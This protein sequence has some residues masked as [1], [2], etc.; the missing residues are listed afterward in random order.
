MTGNLADI[1]MYAKFQD[2]IFG[3]GGVQ[4][5][6]G[7]NLTYSYSFLHGPYNNAVLLCCL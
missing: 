4:F 6:S 7:S 5:Y 2:D 1:I 3:G